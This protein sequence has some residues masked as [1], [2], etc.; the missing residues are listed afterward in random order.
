MGHISVKEATFI[1]KPENSETV[2]KEINEKE[3]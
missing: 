1:Y 2:N 3:I